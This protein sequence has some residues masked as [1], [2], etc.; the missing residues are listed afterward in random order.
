[1]DRQALVS[2]SNKLSKHQFLEHL[3]PS[4]SN[5]QV[6]SDNKHSLRWARSHSSRLVDFSLSHKVPVY[7]VLRLPKLGLAD[8]AQD[9]LE[10]GQLNSHNSHRRPK[11]QDYL[12]LKRPKELLEEDFSE[13]RRRSSQP[14]QASSDRRRKRSLRKPQPDYLGR[15]SPHSMVCS[16]LSKVARWLLHLYSPNSKS[17]PQAVCS[18]G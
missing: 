2:H 18:E 8:K 4:H 5:S 13:A 7:S 11:Q 15:P 16:P 17:N 14:R 9:S 10:L 6:F 3:R 1:M 12:E